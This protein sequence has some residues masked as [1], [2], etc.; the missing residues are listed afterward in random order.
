MFNIGLNRR[1]HML[2]GDKRLAKE[3]S[4]LQCSVIIILPSLVLLLLLLLPQERLLFHPSCSSVLISLLWTRKPE[5]PLPLSQ[6]HGVIS[7]R[8]V[9]M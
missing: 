6:G 9:E 1:V 2:L 8:G 5:C 7:C 3:I 4:L